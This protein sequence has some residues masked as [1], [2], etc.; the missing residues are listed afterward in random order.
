MFAFGVVA[1]PEQFVQISV[2]DTGL[3]MP[4]EVMAQVFEPLFTTKQNGGTGLGLAVA[5]QVLTQHG[6][7]LFVESEPGR[8][9]TFHLFIPQGH[10]ACAEPAEDDS[11]NDLLRSRR[12][13][14]VEDEPSIVEGI[15][16]LL[17]F[18]GIE[19]HAVDRGA[20]AA[21][22]VARFHPDIVLLD[23]G[24]PD[25]DGAAVYARIRGI[26]ASLPVIFAT[27]HGDRHA[28]QDELC[29]PRTRFLQKPFEM[30]TLLEMIG[31]LERSEGAR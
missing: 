23:V 19:V 24:L 30:A 18:S 3:G 28:I 22:A 26:D 7:H 27:G 9:T 29:D 16:E 25:M 15:S 8:G 2:R 4:P 17:A 6:G 1:R 12:L 11:G 20:E 14:I 31:E 5:H 13:L 21:D 10:P